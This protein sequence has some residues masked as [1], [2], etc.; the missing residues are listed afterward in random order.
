[1]FLCTLYVLVWRLWF[2]SRYET[3]KIQSLKLVWGSAFQLTRLKPSGVGEFK[4]VVW[5]L[6]LVLLL[7]WL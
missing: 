3:C 6:W 1:M 5:L 7:W 4:W 2:E